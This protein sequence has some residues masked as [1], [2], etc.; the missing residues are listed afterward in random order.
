MDVEKSWRLQNCVWEITLACCFSCVHC[1]SGGGK[2]RTGELTTKECLDVAGQL[3][4]LGCRRVSLIGGEVF[5][6]AD[7]ARIVRALTDRGILTAIITNG[8]LFTDKVVSQLKRVNV[9]S[10]AVSLD[11]PEQLHDQYRQKGSFARA[12]SAIRVLTEQDIPVSVITTLN[13]G[14]V[15]RLEEMYGI[16]Q[17]FPIFAWQ[18][19]ACSPMGN[20][21]NGAVD[22]RFEQAEVIRFI[23]DHREEAPFR[24]IAADNIGYYT[25]EEKILRG[26]RGRSC[27]HG[28]SAGLTS[29]GIDSVGNVRGCES[30]YSDRFTE[31]NLR[32]MSL[33]EIWESPDAF[34]YNRKFQAEMLTGACAACAFGKYCAGGC[35]S[36]N[37]FVHGKL[38]ESPG[39]A[40]VMRRKDEGSK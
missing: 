20:A 27:F 17:E 19:Q 13:A 22:F 16:L 6:R 23:A 34:S 28:C 32:K 12:L 3:A 10:V 9:E 8:F 30:M 31:G 36:Y 24:M 38:Y 21:G 26:S 29:V 18:L 15:T 40:R 11:G 7:W 2:A 1:G 33:R 39:C 37:Y 5:M 25:K 35:R 4:D 14:N